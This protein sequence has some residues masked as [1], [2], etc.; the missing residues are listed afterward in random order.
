M[1]GDPLR[2]C[3]PGSQG[4]PYS[5]CLVPLGIKIKLQEE[6]GI[7]A[8]AEGWT[9]LVGLAGPKFLE[10]TTCQGRLSSEPPTGLMRGKLTTS[11]LG[12]A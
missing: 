3:L 9:M 4:P 12:A 11:Q 6:Q 8:P 1:S 2:M 5:S 10:K 7:D